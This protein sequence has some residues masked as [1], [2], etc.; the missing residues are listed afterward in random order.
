[1]PKKDPLP[2]PQPPV[3]ADPPAGGRWVRQADGSL[4]PAQD[5]A[6]PPVAADSANL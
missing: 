6:S 4:V 3:D 2:D 1:M 5:E